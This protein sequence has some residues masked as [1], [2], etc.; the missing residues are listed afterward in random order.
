MRE[1]SLPDSTEPGIVLDADSDWHQKLYAM[2]LDTIPSSV[3]MIDQNM[4]VVLANQNFLK[5]SRRS[6]AN[7]I[8]FP[9]EH[10]FPAVIIEEMDITGQIRQVFRSSEPSKGQRMLF[11]APGV[12]MRT[13]YYRIVPFEWQGSVE[14]VM[15][16][17]D[18]VT[19]QIQLSDEIQRVQ[20]HLASIFDSASDII[21]STDTDGRIQSWNRAAERISGYTFAEVK[22]RALYELCAMDCQEN[23]KRTFSEMRIRKDSVTADWNLVTKNGIDVHVSWVCSPMKDQQLETAGIV[24]VGRDHTERRK[25]EMQLRQSQ[26]FAAL[27]VMAGGIAHEIRNPLAVCFS[28]AQFLLADD[29]SSDF[30]IECARKI[31]TGIKRASSVIENLLKFARP[32]EG[33]NREKV[34]ILDVIKETAALVSSQISLQ[35]IALNLDFPAQPVLINGSAGLLQQVFI[36]LFLNGLKAMPNGG[37]LTVSAQETKGSAL[38]RVADTGRGI[39]KENLDKIYDPF[40]TTS[41]VGEGVGLGLSICYAIIEQ[42]SGTIEVESAEGQGTTFSIT[43]PML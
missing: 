41:P 26:K 20:L 13:Y 37:D 29:V 4:R 11:R 34:N 23:V 22:T 8:G 16:L 14:N 9:L 21:L 12:S 17:M 18:D 27:G 3:L 6:E 36:N 39:L 31:H 24:V 33:P 7:T 28:A 25:M 5:K 2:L 1:A 32:P 43:L 10:I 40:F 19:E 35:R 42:H 30:R 15:L 38:I